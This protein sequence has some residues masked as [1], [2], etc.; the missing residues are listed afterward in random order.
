MGVLAGSAI[1]SWYPDPCRFDVKGT[2]VPKAL[3]FQ[4]I[5]GGLRAPILWSSLICATYGGVEC[6]MEQLRDETKQKTS[7]NSA[8]AGAAA[9]VL[10]GSMTKRIDIMATT[11]LGLGLLMGMI[12]HNGQTMQQEQAKC[13]VTVTGNSTDAK[14]SPRAEELKKLYPEFKHL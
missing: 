13:A 14:E 7:I 1:L 3:T 12:E 5:L 11:G 9:G 8:V 6:I 4:H 2:V 10:M